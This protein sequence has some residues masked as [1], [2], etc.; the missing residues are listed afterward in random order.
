MI[1][2]RITDAVKTLFY[3]SLNQ[4]SVARRID[5]LRELAFSVRR[6]LAQQIATQT[7]GVVQAG[8]FSGTRLS[9][10]RLN[11]SERNFVPKICG[12]YEVELTETLLSAASDKYSAI[13]NIG[14]ADGFYAIGLARINK[15]A[16]VFASDTSVAA[17]ARCRNTSV[18][19]GVAD[20]IQV[21]GHLRPE[22][23]EV[24]LVQFARTF[25]ICDCEGSEKSLLDPAKVPSL[26]SAD[27]LVECHDFLDPEI[28]S[29]LKSRL[30][31]THVI[32]LIREGSRD[33]NSTQ[34]LE[35]RESLLRWLGICEF[36]P[37]P[38]H[39]LYCVAKL[40][41]PSG[42]KRPIE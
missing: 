16:L 40:S 7:G 25:I 18:A 15:K 17:Q 22:D 8:I 31:P 20:R 33:P 35:S 34:L 26:A 10:E 36:R 27:V 13:V 19:N 29:I 41:Q 14:C 1:C 30:E 42:S 23:L 37:A 6:D 12:S 28:T 21:V 32:Q 24:I 3:G 39:W 38:M 9:V 11:E 2:S 4:L 5:I